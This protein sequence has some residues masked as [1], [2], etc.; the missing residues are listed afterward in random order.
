MSGTTATEYLANPRTNFRISRNA[1][2]QSAEKRSKVKSCAAYKE[3]DVISL[4]D[5]SN[6]LA[7]QPCKAPR[8]KIFRWINYVYKVMRNAALFIGRNLCC[9]NVQPAIDLYRIAAY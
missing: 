5:L 8:S 6:C 9:C 2:K 7:G 4:F 3:N 1:F